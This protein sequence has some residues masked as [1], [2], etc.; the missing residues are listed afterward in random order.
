M[1]AA[2]GGAEGVSIDSRA[3]SDQKASEVSFFT[4]PESTGISGLSAFHETHA[5]SARVEVTTIAEIAEERGIAGADFLKID[6]EGFDYSVLKGVPWDRFKP[7]VIE[8]EFEDAKTVPLG[9][10]WKEIAHFLQ[11]KGYAVYVSEWHPIVRYGIAHDWRRVFRFGDGEVAP[12]AWG[13]LLAFRNDPGLATVGSAF[14][15]CLKFPDAAPAPTKQTAEKQPRNS[16]GQKDSSPMNAPIAKPAP[17]PAEIGG[18]AALANRLRDSSPRTFAI[19]RF[20]KRILTQL[21]VRRRWTLPAL[22]VALGAYALTLLPLFEGKRFEAFSVLSLF[23]VAVGVLYLAFRMYALAE[24][25]LAENNALRLQ[26]EGQTAQSSR[27]LASAKRQI[28]ASA[29]RSSQELASVKRSLDSQGSAL[30]ASLAAADKRRQDEQVQLAKSLEGVRL[31]THRLA[32][33]IGAAN[34]TITETKARIDKT[35]SLLH[36]ARTKITDLRKA[37]EAAIRLIDAA[38]GLAGKSFELAKSAP[39]N[40][41]LFYQRFNRKLTAEHADLLS[42]E[43]APKIGVDFSPATLGYLA[44]RACHIEAMSEGRLATSIENILLRSLVCFSVKRPELEIL[45]IGTLFGIGAAVMHD[46][47][48]P[49][50]RRVHLSL[51]DPL[52]G[53]YASERKDILTGQPVNETAL[54]RN[55]A[56][57]GVGEADFTIIKRLSTDAEAKTAAALRSYDVL[58]IDGDHSYQGVKFDFDHYAPLVRPGGLVIIDDYHSPDWPD[59]TRFVDDEV[60][61]RKGFSLFGESWRT[62]VYKVDD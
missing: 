51:L 31:N 36:D 52:D 59:V 5:E 40:N 11:G 19:A 15:D 8:C 13:N 27:A 4:S 57:A 30:R 61:K 38:K 29:N 55:L 39:P 12:D 47:L 34:A 28:E 50:Y 54:R 21:W 49:H 37:D 14:R 16:A 35:D 60:S 2:F 3:V 26:L 46:A 23:F 42:R 45:E 53:Y 17:A 25:L 44:S 1:S 56:R 6:V 18:Y 20:G 33:E 22:F 62:C 24:R 58:V 32:T 43:W 9:H 41:A 10:D 48:A 7:D